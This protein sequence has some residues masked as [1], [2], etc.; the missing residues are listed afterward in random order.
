MVYTI[1]EQQL[2]NKSIVSILC[3]LKFLDTL[4]ILALWSTVNEQ[5]TN[6]GLLTFWVLFANIDVHA[7]KK[8][9]T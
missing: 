8:F 7:G 9:N 2:E 3:F 5:Y 6:A 1:V 4:A